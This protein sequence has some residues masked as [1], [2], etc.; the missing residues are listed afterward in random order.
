MP[1]TPKQ[2]PAELENLD[3]REVSVVDRP[4]NRRRF[5]IV[6]REG[7]LAVEETMPNQTQVQKDET[8]L[9]EVLGLGDETTDA[10][11]A[12]QT[13]DASTG[14]EDEEIVL[15]EK[16]TKATAAAA[17]K[18]IARFTKLAN[19][20]KK[21]CEKGDETPAT[22]ASEM[23]S[24]VKMCRGI[25]GKLG[26]A[27]TAKAGAAKQVKASDAAKVVAECLKQ[28]MD[29]ST[30]LK[31]AGDA[32]VTPEAMGVMEAV[33]EALDALMSEEAAPPASGPPAAQS[34]KGKGK[35]GETDGEPAA[36]AEE[37][38]EVYK[39]QTPEGVEVVLKVGAKMKK[40]RLNQFE[41]ALETLNSLLKELKGEAAQPAPAAKVDPAATVTKAVEDLG[42]KVEQMLAAKLEPL[43]KRIEAVENASPGGNGD[44]E[45]H[46]TVEPVSKRGA[47][48]WGGVFLGAPSRDSK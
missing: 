31:A 4:A 11:S 13:A 42:A 25:A 30:K 1:S 35:G 37:P 2:T 38:L 46:E 15:V 27:K 34:D 16:G 21:A 17:N 40:M 48:I 26:S 39:R 14:V 12:G 6:K 7:G 18:L 19:A 10:G 5:L 41:K 45:P 29:L 24:L 20:L 9:L 47:N 23:K 32:D 44:A 22:V 28:L 3:V 36:K 8:G 33:C 43:A